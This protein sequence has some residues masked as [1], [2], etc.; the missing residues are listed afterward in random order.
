MSLPVTS[1]IAMPLALFM[2]GLAWRVAMLRRKHKIGL[3]VSKNQTLAKAMAA[4]SNAVENT[5]LALVLFAL[6]E[7]QGADVVLL[8]VWGVLFV[9]ARF[10]N[11]FGVS[12]HAGTS[13][14][15]FYGII[16]SWFCI[17]FL[18]GLNLWLNI[19]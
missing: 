15:R 14:G 9:I 18:A 5:P 3:G 19:V 6:A 17:I 10:L 7:L 2:I 13:F 16:L 12:L 4:H 8:S 1:F 11:A